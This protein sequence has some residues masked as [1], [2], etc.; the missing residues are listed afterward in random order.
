MKNI[1][2]LQKLSKRI[3]KLRSRCVHALMKKGLSNHEVMRYRAL[4]ENTVKAQAWL[5]NQ[6]VY[7][8]IGLPGLRPT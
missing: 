8:R 7:R 2:Q 1:R 3:P 5:A 4:L 6:L